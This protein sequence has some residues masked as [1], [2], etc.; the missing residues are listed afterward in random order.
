M[1]AKLL[2]AKQRYSVE[3]ESNEERE[4]RFG[5][6]VQENRAEWKQNIAKACSKIALLT[7]T[8]APLVESVL[9][10]VRGPCCRSRS[11]VGVNAPDA[12]RGNGALLYS[13]SSYSSSP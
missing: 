6:V 8:S 13:S 4:T 3:G 5:K 11:G 2:K 7:R 9:Q 10:T 1:L 12:K